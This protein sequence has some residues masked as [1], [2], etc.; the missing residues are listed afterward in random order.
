[1]ELLKKIIKRTV[2]PYIGTGNRDRPKDLTIPQM[3][4]GLN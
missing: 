3:Q 1:M 4:L 2:F